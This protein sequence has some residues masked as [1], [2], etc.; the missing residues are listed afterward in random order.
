MTVATLTEYKRD[1]D[2]GEPEMDGPRAVSH[3]KVGTSWQTDDGKMLDE[4]PDEYRVE[5]EECGGE[6]GN[7]GAAENH[8]ETEHP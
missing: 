5:C 1:F 6:F 7:W 2:P 8:A 4:N 3:I